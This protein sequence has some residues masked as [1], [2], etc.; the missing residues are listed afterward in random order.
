MTICSRKETSPLD[1]ADAQR[2][3]ASTRVGAKQ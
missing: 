1:L 2:I 3:D